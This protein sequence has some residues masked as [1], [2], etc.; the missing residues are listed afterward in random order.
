M[1]DRVR[2]SKGQY[3]GK[4][5]INKGVNDS[6]F[7]AAASQN[8]AAPLTVK[9][10][11]KNLTPTECYQLCSAVRAAV[12]AR[13]QPYEQVKIRL[14]MKKSGQE[15]FGGDIYNTIMQPNK[16]QDGNCFLKDLASWSDLGGERA[17]HCHKMNNEEVYHVMNPFGMLVVDPWL[18][19]YPEEIK[20]WQYMHYNGQLEYILSEDVFY[21][22]NWNP[23]SPVRGTSPLWS[24]TNSIGASY[25]AQRY[26]RSFFANNARVD[27]IITLD[28]QN[29]D[30]LTAFKEEYLS[31]HRGDDNAFKTWI[32]SGVNKIDVKQMAQE[33]QDAPFQE[34]I[35]NVNTEVM[36]VY[37]VPPLLGGNFDAVRFDSAE[38]QNRVFFENCWLPEMHNMQKYLQQF[39]DQELQNGTIENYKKPVM[40]KSM[41][42]RF[43]KLR[44]VAEGSVVIILDADSIAGVAELQKHKVAYSQILQDTFHITPRA[45][46]KE[47]GI[48]LD[49]NEAADLPW[50]N[51]SQKFMEL[52]RDNASVVT[53]EEVAIN[54]NT[55][56]DEALV[57]SETT[58]SDEEKSVKEKLKSFYHELRKFTFDKMEEGK[59]W[60]LQEVDNFAKSHKV[61]SSRFSIELRK[62]FNS[63]RPL[64][65][66]KNVDEIKKY[67]NKKNNKY[68]NKIVKEIK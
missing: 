54:E 52:K 43:D 48:E 15:I 19:R 29:N 24:L 66:N 58:M 68:L 16:Y 45:S 34:L 39:I 32:M 42:N 7:G 5:P 61:Y 41:E 35:K 8:A 20:K 31:E 22:H 10:I 17:I 33:T 67:L 50:F 53:P 40:T 49:F 25:M 4:N 23:S 46:A 2:N 44:G 30:E 12:R 14:F 1:T 56:P 37:S 65:L 51:S 3:V 57:E 6:Y 62:D 11:I 28:T 63:L 13:T 59:I 18:P 21:R 38:E 60:S 27:Q 64:C 47:I 9:N 26:I 36:K 55:K